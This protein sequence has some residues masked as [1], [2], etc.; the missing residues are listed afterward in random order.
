VLD[1]LVSLAA[2][3]DK[4]GV[5]LTGSLE[6]YDLAVDIAATQALREQMR[7]KAQAA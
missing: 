2:A 6:E 4:Y 5:V 7:T 3:K 1:E